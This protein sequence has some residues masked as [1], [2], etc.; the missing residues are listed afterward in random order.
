MNTLIRHIEYLLSRTDC[1]II[2]GIGALLA[3]YEEASIDSDNQIVAPPYRSFSFNSA[4]SNSDGLL[5]YSISRSDGVSID[6]ATSRV[7]ELAEAMRRQMCLDGKLSIGKIGTLSLDPETG[8]TVFSDFG[9]DKLSVQTAWLPKVEKLKAD[10]SSL[11]SQIDEIERP[12]ISP[13]V[14]FIKAAAS[15]ALLLGICLV[16]STPIDVNEA[17]FASLSPEVRTLHD[18]DLIPEEPLDEFEW[19]QGDDE[20]LEAVNLSIQCPSS[21]SNLFIETPLNIAEDN[22]KYLVIVASLI[23]EADACAFIKTHSDLASG[24]IEQN[25]RYRVYSASYPTQ[26]EAYKAIAKMNPS[27]SAW[28]CKK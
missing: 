9:Q 24:W 17:V 26:T 19:N 3:R 21:T 28:V 20:I 2:P 23:S 12:R 7:K 13:F 22:D 25:G 11:A 15:V 18:T 8:L 16:A 6:V 10:D 14:R 27:V 5:A 4:L 1:V